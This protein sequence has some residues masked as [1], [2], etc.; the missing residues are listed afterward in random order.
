EA[1]PRPA[2]GELRRALHVRARPPPG[3][4]ERRRLAR[5]D[6]VRR[7]RARAREAGR[8]VSLVRVAVSVDHVL[9]GGHVAPTADRALD[10]LSGGAVVVLV[11]V[12]ELEL[13]DRAV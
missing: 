5:A 13:V 11:V 4:H 3:A 10:A 1:H 8:D 6:E 9:S 12:G 7:R 2:P